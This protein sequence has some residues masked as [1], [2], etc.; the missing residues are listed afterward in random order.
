MHWG[1]AG[2]V[3]IS[4]PGL[5]SPHEPYG[6]VL[7]PWCPAPELPQPCPKDTASSGS[8][9]F[10]QLIQ[11]GGISTLYHRWKDSDTIYHWRYPSKKKHHSPL[12]WC[13][14]IST[15]KCNAKK[16]LAERKLLAT[17]GLLSAHWSQCEVVFDTRHPRH[18][19]IQIAPHGLSGEKNQC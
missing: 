15:P 1:G 18:A 9:D 14:S 11:Q 16:N 10:T 13:K 12:K 4:S 3:S 2:S 17:K 8:W 6:A 5:V 19:C 7:H